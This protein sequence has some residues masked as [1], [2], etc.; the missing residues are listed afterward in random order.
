MK[1]LILSF[2]LIGLAQQPLPPEGRGQDPAKPEQLA[3]MTFEGE[4][5]KIDV[6]AKT[7]MVKSTAPE[8]EMVFA[9]DEKTEVVGS[10]TGIQGLMG[11][12][13]ARLKISYRE[14]KGTNQATKI[15]IQAQK[16]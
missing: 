11:N 12:S 5:S 3:P 10:E 14:E 9:Y 6:Q 1:G 15:E 16:V 13:G 8:K 2:L 7:I 4:L